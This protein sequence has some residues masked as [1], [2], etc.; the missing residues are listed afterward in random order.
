MPNKTMNYLNPSISGIN[1]VSKYVRDVAA[2]V[3]VPS[4]TVVATVVG[5]VIVIALLKNY[6]VDFKAGKG[7][8]SL[9]CK[10]ND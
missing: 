1:E 5:G 10:S 2:N 6:D 8:I 4:G 3:A 7:E 9:A